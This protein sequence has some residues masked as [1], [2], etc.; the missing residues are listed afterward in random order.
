MY[1]W[2]STD[3]PA[4]DQ[5]QGTPDRKLH[6]LPMSWLVG[7]SNDWEWMQFTGLLDKNGKEIYEGDIIDV[8]REGH[9]RYQV[10]W[11][12]SYWALVNKNGNIGIISIGS[13]Q[14]E[15]IGNIHENPE[16]LNS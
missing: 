5:I 13:G 2:D 4:I 1:Y 9:H 12:P 8:T 10:E 16:L 3:H 7:D 15:V 14:K 6:Y 11:Y